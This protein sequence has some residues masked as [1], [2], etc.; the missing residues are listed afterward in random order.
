MEDISICLFL[1]FHQ[2]ILTISDLNAGCLSIQKMIGGQKNYSFN[3]F[4]SFLQVLEVFG[5]GYSEDV[6]LKKYK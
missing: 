3:N 2:L 6:D 4:T 1:L 5:S